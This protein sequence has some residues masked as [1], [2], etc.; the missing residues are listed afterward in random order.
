MTARTL[1]AVVLAAALCAACTEQKPSPPVTVVDP[2]YANA[3]Q[4]LTEWASTRRLV[5]AVLA[6]PDVPERAKARLSGLIEVTEPAIAQVESALQRHATRELQVK[7]E[8][9]RAVI[10]QFYAEDP[11]A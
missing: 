8:A 5:T 7:V 9:A 10:R 6:D 4:V 2:A 3:R 1:L 11:E